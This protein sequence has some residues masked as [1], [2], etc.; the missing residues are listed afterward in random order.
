MTKKFVILF[1]ILFVFHINVFADEDGHTNTTGVGHEE[2]GEGLGLGHEKDDWIVREKLEDEN[3]YRYVLKKD[4]RVLKEA[5]GEVCGQL[6]D[7][8]DDWTITTYPNYS[9]NSDRPVLIARYVEPGYGVRYDK[10]GNNSYD[11]FCNDENGR[12]GTVTNTKTGLKDQFFYQENGSFDKYINYADKSIDT[13][14]EAGRQNAM[15]YK[16]RSGEIKTNRFTFDSNGTQ[17]GYIRNQKSTQEEKNLYNEYYKG[18]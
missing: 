4:G 5:V 15:I 11:I 6:T 14:N 3:G 17:T 8:G 1:S 18:K 16:T 9:T 2:H 13:Y 7:P 12:V 10:Y